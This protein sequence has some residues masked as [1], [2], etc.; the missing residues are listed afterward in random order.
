MFLGVYAQL[1]TCMAGFNVFGLVYGIF[2]SW[3]EQYKIATKQQ[4]TSTTKVPQTEEERRE[5]RKNALIEQV[6]RD[7]QQRERTKKQD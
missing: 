7:R 1:H 4:Q 5:A 3:R 2:S 6:L